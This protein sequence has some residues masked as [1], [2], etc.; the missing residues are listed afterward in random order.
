MSD[1]LTWVQ[2]SGSRDAAALDAV[3]PIALTAAP[4]RNVSFVTSVMTGAISDVTPLIGTLGT[5]AC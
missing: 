2:P 4:G 1:A 5:P 3:L